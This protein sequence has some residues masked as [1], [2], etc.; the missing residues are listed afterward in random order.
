MTGCRRAADRSTVAGCESDAAPPKPWAL[1]HVADAPTPTRMAGAGSV[2]QLRAF[3][4]APRQVAR[5]TSRQCTRVPRTSGRA[6]GDEHSLSRKGPDMKF[7]V[8]TVSALAVWVLAAA[9]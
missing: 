3:R 8:R 1:R 4:R 7:P 2:R 9:F 5:F 6:R